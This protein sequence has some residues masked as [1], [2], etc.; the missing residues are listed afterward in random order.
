MRKC[1]LWLLLSGVLAAGAGAPQAQL[2]QLR[3]L[4]EKGER[5][6]L[7]EKQSLPL[8]KIGSRVL[9]LAP[10]GLIFDQHNRTIVHANLPSGADILYTRDQSGDIQRIYI[11]TDQERAALDQRRR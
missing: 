2:L 10:G 9:K 1:L 8:V 3:F 7:G 6:R 4:P 11:L 5:G